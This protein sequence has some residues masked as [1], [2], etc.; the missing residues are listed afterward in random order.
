MAIILAF[1]AFFLI[2]Y[3]SIPQI[4]KFA[5]ARKL[6]DTPDHR[7]V[8]RTLIPALGGV[9]VFICI[10][11]AYLFKFSLIDISNLALLIGAAIIFFTGVVDD[12]KPQ[13]AM[14]KLGLQV[15]AT[16]IIVFVGDFRILSLFGTFD[17]FQL[18]YFISAGISV[19]VILTFINALNLIDGIN[20]LA[21]GLGI[22]FFSFFAFFYFHS[23]QLLFLT[24]SIAFVSSLLAFLRY[25]LIKPSIFL[26]DTGST[27]I[28][29]FSAVFLIDFLNSPEFVKQS[30][31]IFNP[32]GLMLSLFILPLFDT[33]RVTLQ[34]ILN[35]KSPF[36][37]DKTHIHHL[38]L[39][40]DF[41]HYH[42]TAILIFFNLFIFAISYLFQKKLGDL[43]TITLILGLFVLGFFIIE[44][45]LLKKFK[46]RGE[47][48]MTYQK[49]K[50]FISEYWF[51]FFSMIVFA[52]PFQRWATSIPILVYT[53]IWILSIDFNDLKSSISQNYKRFFP[54]FIYLLPFLYFI[55]LE[56]NFSFLNTKLG[57]YL[58]FLV[59]PILLFLRNEYFDLKKWYAILAF[60]LLG[61]LTFSGAFTS[62]VFIKFLS[63]N[64]T[65]LFEENRLILSNI[66]IIYY[67]LFLNFAIM[68]AIYLRKSN[69]KILQSD[70][71]TVGIISFLAVNMLIIHS[72]IGFC[73][74][75]LIL[76]VSS[77]I[78]YFQ[79]RKF[80]VIA[81][82]LIVFIIISGL[83]FYSPAKLDL[84]HLTSSSFE[85]TK[86][87][88]IWESS[89]DLIQEKFI[90]GYGSKASPILAARTQL[91]LNAHNLFLQFYLEYGLIGF[92]SICVLMFH[93]F[94]NAIK[95][96]DYFYK[97]FLFLILIYG[98]FESLFSNQSGIVFFT[99][100]NS[101]LLLK[102]R[103]RIK[104]ED[105]MI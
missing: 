2:S 99:I 68:T 14:L 37:P 73:V 92:V 90:I 54:A 28:G 30:L 77:I 39:R 70:V 9:A 71:I 100:F 85:V 72:K 7:K 53:L 91:N 3:F 41:Q 46:L 16:G 61:V 48:I 44:F 89:I 50:F 38:F 57:L 33:F 11:L 69:I 78:T 96:R 29:L 12:I 4:V 27:I 76:F 84:N 63:G 82:V 43:L 95:S 51:L 75:L 79:F 47:D 31:H 5:I 101:L 60:Y 67:S 21:A 19:F 65:N 83:L 49:F 13:K 25:N 56:Q 80:P 32:Y 22:M 18:N 52:L 64:Y 105:K 93:S 34:R 10:V 58:P 98:L 74:M 6:V 15:L 87:I 97:G 62:I 8:H 66:P 24:I 17:I 20:G 55:L 26:G 88:H 42:I 40:L 59:F 104:M 102:S 94:I 45:F 103:L 1:L 81:Y 23:E 36:S 35:Q 86:R